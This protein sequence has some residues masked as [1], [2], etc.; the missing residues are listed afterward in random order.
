MIGEGGGGNRKQRTFFASG[1]L[2]KWK[3]AE[4]RL[5]NVVVCLV[6]EMGAFECSGFDTDH[7]TPVPPPPVAASAPFQVARDGKG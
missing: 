2:P 6:V 7:V 5:Q 1:N 3:L 4:F